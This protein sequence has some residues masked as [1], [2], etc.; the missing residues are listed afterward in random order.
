M[1]LALSFGDNAFFNCSTLIF[2]M[3][4]KAIYHFDLFT[5]PATLRIKG[6]TDKA[7]ACSGVFSIFLYIAFTA[8]FVV[9]V[10]EIFEYKKI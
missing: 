7:N 8:I 6:E 3:I 9:S 4:R 1:I 2:T 5:A 10:I